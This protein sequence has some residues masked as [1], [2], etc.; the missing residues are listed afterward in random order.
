MKKLWAVLAGLAAAIVVLIVVEMI[1]HFI[2]PSPV[3]LDQKDPVQVHAYLSSLPAF[4][5]FIVIIGH[6][7]AM[8]VAS[9]VANMILRESKT[10]NLVSLIFGGL[11]IM[12]IMMVHHPRWFVVADVSAVL[13]AYLMSKRFFKGM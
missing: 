7:L 3:N 10:T 11:V 1:S 8:L 12:N 4:A 5:Y 9:F 2:Y 6:F 13:L